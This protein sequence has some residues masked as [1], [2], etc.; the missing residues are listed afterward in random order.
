MHSKKMLNSNYVGLYEKTAFIFDFQ[1]C[2]VPQPENTHFHFHAFFW[3]GHLPRVKIESKSS[4]LTKLYIIT[5]INFL[6]HFVL[7]LKN[8]TFDIPLYFQIFRGRVPFFQAKK[9]NFL[10][11]KCVVFTS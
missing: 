6:E 7:Y 8:K 3:F 4:F 5:V 11:A 10:V 2:K 1:P 9:L